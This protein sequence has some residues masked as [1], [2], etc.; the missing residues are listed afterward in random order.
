MVG[1]KDGKIPGV[2]GCSSKVGSL[3]EINE[4]P[5]AE[6]LDDRRTSILDIQL[7]ELALDLGV[8]EYSGGRVEIR[9]LKNKL[10]VNVIDEEL[11]RRSRNN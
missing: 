8:T 10:I 3:M 4:F 1:D 6:L 11:A 5:L 9:K 2:E 7:C